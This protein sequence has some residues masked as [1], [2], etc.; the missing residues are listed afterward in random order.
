MEPTRIAV[1]VGMGLVTYLIRV[2]PQVLFVGQR[3]PEMFD[4]Y[5]RFLA[6]ALIASII[7]TSL[8]L[9][10]P[11]FD[12]TAAPSRALALGAAILAAAWSR[13][14]ALGMLTGTLVAL[15]LSWLR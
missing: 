5:L 12:A 11:R 4:R 1:I 7:S 3:F 14:P 9:S 13:R 10:G 6:Y 15:L 8:F 2:A